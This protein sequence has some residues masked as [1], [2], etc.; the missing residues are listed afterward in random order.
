[1][2]RLGLLGSGFISDTY[3]DALRDVR[4]AEV[5]ANYS[6][7][8][9]RAESFGRRWGIP[10]QYDDMAALCSRGDID[11]VVVALP[12][13]VHVDAVRVAA[14]AGKA[15]VC[16]KPL[17]R[18][19]AEAAEILRIVR[20]HGVWHGYAESSVFSPNIAKAHEMVA[21][22][23]IGQVLTMRAREAHSG[24]HAAHFWD[25][26]TA[27]GGALLDMGCHTVESARHFFG[28]DNA[29][30]EVMAWGATMMHGDK[31][32]GEDTAIALLKFAG[33]QLATIESSWIEKGGMALR[34]EFVGSAGRIVTDT[35]NTPVW[36]FIENPA[37]YLVEKADAE[38]G[39]VYPVPEEAR[40]YGFSQEMRHFV[41]CYAAGVEPMETFDDGWTVNTI[42]DACYASMRSGAWEKIEW[43]R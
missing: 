25:A 20:E 1:M 35:S 23:A 18:T 40:A 13:E 7:D 24:P 27:G 15:I 19:G 38:T 22:G 8:L 14:Q 12:N 9:T 32:T 29:V 4:N 2:I 16:T 33:G 41:D 31:T 26:E 39:W 11:M 42:I 34:H 17:A 3:A 10:D 6:R 37:G 36:G 28:K 5:V 43:A 21:A 30:T